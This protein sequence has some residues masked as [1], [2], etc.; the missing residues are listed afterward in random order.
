MYLDCLLPIMCTALSHYN[1]RALFGKVGNCAV[2]R[3]IFLAPKLGAKVSDFRA[4]P[5]SVASSNQLLLLTGPSVLQ[6]LCTYLCFEK[7]SHHP[8]Y[9]IGRWC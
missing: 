8:L 6:L 7:P 3:A 4:T 9:N 1:D 5:P 2:L